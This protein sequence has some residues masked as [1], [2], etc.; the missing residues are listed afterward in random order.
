[1]SK[2]ISAICIFLFIFLFADSAFSEMNFSVVGSRLNVS[3]H[4][5]SGVFDESNPKGEATDTTGG[6]VDILFDAAGRLTT[7][8]AISGN[9]S[10]T[11]SIAKIFLEE[12]DTVTIFHDEDYKK[13]IIEALAGDIV[14]T[15]PDSARMVLPEGAAIMLL[16]SADGSYL[17]SVVKGEVEY[18]DPMGNTRIINVRTPVIIIKLY[19]TFFPGWGILEPERNPATP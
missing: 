2:H 18:T 19:T 4:E 9:S 6:K 7:V 14:I 12:K 15:L 16:M 13:T 10:F 11:F 5:G 3:A 1:M 17:L 8:E